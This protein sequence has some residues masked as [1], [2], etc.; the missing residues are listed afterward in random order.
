MK[1]RHNLRRLCAALC[2]L[3]LI[4]AMVP[5][6]FAAQAGSGRTFSD[7]NPGDWYY[8]KVM[9]LVEKGA[10]AGYP[11]GTFKPNDKVTIAEFC[12]MAMGAFPSKQTAEEALGRSTADQLMADLERRNPGYWANKTIFEYK[13][14]RNLSGPEPEQDIWDDPVDR[15]VA[16]AILNNTFF[17]SHAGDGFENTYNQS[18]AGY[19]GDY[20]SFRYDPLAPAVL[21]GYYMGI[22]NG[23]DENHSFLPNK[24]LTR[25][26]AC[27]YLRNALHMTM[28]G[29][30]DVTFEQT[31]LPDGTDFQGKARIHYAAD[32][33]Y[34]LCRELEEQIGMPI[35]YLPEFTP[36]ES[37]LI[38]PEDMN[39]MPVDA[40]YFDLVRGE[41]E[42]MK[43]AY[44]LY[45][46]G[47]LK[48]VAER[49]GSRDVEIILCPYTF[50]G[51]GSYGVHVYDSSS[52]SHKVDQIYYTG[53]GD[54]RYYSH[55]MGH[56]VMSSA[57]ML[58]GWSTVTGKWESLNASAGRGDYVS[59]Y[60]MASRPEDW[61]E[62]W[63]S[64]W[65]DTDSVRGAIAGGSSILQEKVRYMTEVMRVYNTFRAAE[66]PWEDLL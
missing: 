15:I 52:D 19:I 49:K 59:E 23:V 54:A 18:V 30:G 61:A 31:R 63:A 20:E 4:L 36:K 53:I 37:G 51:V 10:I 8:D 56:L 43:A 42:K 13:Y 9:E 62:T 2:A 32:T 24:N 26:E 57:A 3:A 64:L 55:E 5:S 29:P 1:R 34:D 45:P 7:V 39:D 40:A 21:W 60:A 14:T 65:H 58:T 33:A 47:F 6:A 44:S 35:Y 27:T 66:L 50:E 17:S 38:Q 22:L 11:D 46:D 28:P 41:L 25:A 16:I 12:A 48:E